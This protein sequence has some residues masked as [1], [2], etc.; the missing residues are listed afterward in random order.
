MDPQMNKLLKWSVQNSQNEDGTTDAPAS[1]RN[2]TPDM[3]NALFGG[4]SEADLM[5]AAMEVLH[6]DDS[7]LENKLIAFDNFEQMIESIDN[8]NNLEPLGLWSPLA[9][10]LQHEDADMRR[11]AAWC[12]GTAVQ[13][14]EKA[15]DKLVVLNVIPTLVNMST[16][17][18][19][20]ATRKKA[21]YAL[22]SAVRNYQP[23][24]NELV[25]HLPEG[26]PSD[27]ADAGDME[28]VDAIMDKLRSHPV[29][30]S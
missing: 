10:L 20:P 29:E 1:A 12:I 21:V 28:A 26:Y 23:C 14:N 3:I 17:D 30:S 13:N 22:S 5:K 16:T 2:L 11:M 7:D 24:M 8:A 6:S 15:Q 4:P 27:K 25:K 9:Q 18:P 19:N